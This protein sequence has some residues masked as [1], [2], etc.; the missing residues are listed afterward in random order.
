MR[1]NCMHDLM[2]EGRRKPVLYST[3]PPPPEF[4]DGQGL[5]KW[6][7]SERVRSL[8]NSTFSVAG[9]QLLADRFHWPEESERLV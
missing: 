6:R 8:D 1:E 9:R 7:L 5:L 2:R 4:F 3:S